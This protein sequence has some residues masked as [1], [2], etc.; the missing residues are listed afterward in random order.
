MI[1]AT[2][3][4]GCLRKEEKPPCSPC[5][6]LG[7]RKGPKGQ[8]SREKLSKRSTNDTSECCPVESKGSVKFSA[9]KIR[10]EIVEKGLPYK[11][12]EAI[13][14]ENRMIIRIQKESVKDEYDPPCDCH[15]EDQSGGRSE[16]HVVEEQDSENRTVT[17]YPQVQSRFENTE[18]VEVNKKTEEEEETIETV[19]V[20]ENPN[21]FLLRVKKKS[22]DGETVALEFKA[23]RAWS[24]EKR[25]EFY[26]RVHQP[27]IVKSEEVVDAP[28]GTG[29]KESKKRKKKEKRKKQ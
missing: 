16:E 25:M 22:R 29:K 7:K 12:L 21:I 26:E 5:C 10:S 4:C 2:H 6:A 1:V 23:P 13:V 3:R 11:E 9:R 15:E 17:V 28:K 18:K 8:E 27:S 19:S 24:R 20:E 14:N